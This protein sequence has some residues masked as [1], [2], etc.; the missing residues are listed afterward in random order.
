MPIKYSQLFGEPYILRR[1]EIEVNQKKVKI[2]EFTYYQELLFMLYFNEGDYIK[3][4]KYICPEL[5]EEEIKNLKNSEKELIEK[6]LLEV[7]ESI[8][9]DMSDEKIE[10]G[11]KIETTFPESI[12]YLCARYG[13]K[14]PDFVNTYSR[15]MINLLNII[16]RRSDNKTYSDKKSEKDTKTM[17]QDDLHKLIARTKAKE[18][19]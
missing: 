19:R 2:Q 15:N 16:A 10:E 5:D 14:M 9:V 6:A 3:R 17:S 7:N 4:I 18:K 1:K 13:G 8:E 12:D 11:D